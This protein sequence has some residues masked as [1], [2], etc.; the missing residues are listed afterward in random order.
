MS[1]RY[2]KRLVFVLAFLLG[3][4]DGLVEQRILA[5]RLSFPLPYS[6]IS[7]SCCT[8]R[9]FCIVSEQHKVLSSFTKQIFVYFWLFSNKVD[10][11]PQDRESQCWAD[12]FFSSLGT[13]LPCSTFSNLLE[14][15]LLF[16]KVLENVFLLIN[17]VWRWGLVIKLVFLLAPRGWESPEAVVSLSL[18]CLAQIVPPYII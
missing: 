16:V 11:Y 10:S 5:H 4:S 3:C 14:S 6:F 15:D 13:P 9:P 7:A 1:K 2:V 12:V 17:N 8:L 18:G